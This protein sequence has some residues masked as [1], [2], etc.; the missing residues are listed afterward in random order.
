MFDA[1]IAPVELTTRKGTTI[2]DTDEHPRP[3]VTLEKL[4][5]LKTVFKKEGVV[6]A[7]NAS[8]QYCSWTSCVE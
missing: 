3:D 5:R 4:A 6:T 1:E 8:G 7:A 2:F